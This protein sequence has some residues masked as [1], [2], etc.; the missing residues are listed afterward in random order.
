MAIVKKSWG[1]RIQGYFVTGLI[2]VLPLLLTVLIMKWIAG[3]L[4]GY[5]GPRTIF[6]QMLQ[7]VGYKFSPISNLTLAYF[8]GI[9]LLVLGIFLLGVLLESGARKTLSALAQKTVYQL[10]MVRM[11]YQTTDKF[12]NLMPSGGD[13]NMKGMRVVFI[14]FGN[15]SS[16]PGSLALMPSMEVYSI[17]GKD[18]WIVIIPTAPIPVGGAML[19]VP[20]DCV[21]STDMNMDNFAVSFVSLG[22]TTSQFNVGPPIPIP[23]RP[24]E[25]AIEA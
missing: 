22:V 21:F 25:P 20:T 16:S 9:I 15:A 2:A 18:H 1:E 12:V 10:P 8:V 17:G 6:G 7:K 3:T 5:I 13:E 4:N 24:V 23:N 11:I 14:K 19:F